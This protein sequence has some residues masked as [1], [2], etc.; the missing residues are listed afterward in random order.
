MRPSGRAPCWR[1]R[2]IRNALLDTG[3]WAPIGAAP[4]GQPWRLG[5]ANPRDSAQ[6][7]TM[8]R[9]DGRGLAVSTDVQLRFGPRPGRT[10]PATTTS[11]TRAPAG[12]HRTCRRWW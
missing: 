2:G 12:H 11:S 1:N 9:A 8:L 7:L 10:T 5:L 3:E 6:V 4:D